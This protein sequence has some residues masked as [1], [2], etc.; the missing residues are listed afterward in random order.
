MAEQAR[1]KPLPAMGD[2]RIGGG[3]IKDPTVGLH[4]LQLAAG[5]A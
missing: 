1:R 2:R 3:A 5:A 4:C